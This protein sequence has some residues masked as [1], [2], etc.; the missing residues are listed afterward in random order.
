M[1]VQRT[2]GRLV[3]VNVNPQGGVPKLSVPFAEITAA[4]VRGDKQN[5]RRHH[6]GPQ[7]AVSL[8]ALERIEA[9]R[10]E[11]HPITPGSTGENLTISGLDWEA[12]GIGD[13]LV[14]GDWVELE[15]TGYAAPCRTIAAAF[16]D[17]AFGRIGQQ[18]HPGWSRLYA[19]VNSE[20][21]V[22]PGD[23]VEWFPR[24]LR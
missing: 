11:G 15:I 14:V 24:Q 19:R 23:L 22:R 1:T 17:G 13:R 8:Y 4:G 2:L 18:T 7:R 10:A 20:G 3:H 21:D 5:D 16:V 9:L 6:G 12:I